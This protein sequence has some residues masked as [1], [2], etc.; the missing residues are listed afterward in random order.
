MP[1]KCCTMWNGEACRTN[2]DGTKTKESE[3][4][5]VHGF[6]ASPEQE[7]WIRSLPNTKYQ[8]TLEFVISTGQLIVQPK[9]FKVALSVPLIHHQF[10]G[11]LIHSTLHKR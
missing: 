2:Y 7:R 5:S 3:K 4:G 1:R 8:N 9:R 6:P 11:L 10:L